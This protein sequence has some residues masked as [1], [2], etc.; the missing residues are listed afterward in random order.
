M[1]TQSDPRLAV[2]ADALRAGRVGVYA[3][4]PGE[5]KKLIEAHP[6]KF[7]LPAYVGPLGW[8]A[9]QLDRGKV[10][11]AEVRDLVTVSCS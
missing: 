7:Y 1:E 2:Q 6:R 8:V 5:N 9:L 11:W 10:D 3:G 4:I